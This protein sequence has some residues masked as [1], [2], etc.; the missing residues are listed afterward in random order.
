M[1]TLNWFDS[2]AAKPEGA[3][4]ITIGGDWAPI[5]TYEA[6]AR[7]RGAEIHGDL[8]PLLRESDF[9]LFN[10]E[11]V[12][13]DEGA[14]LSKPGP[15]L[16]AD[17]E[18]SISTLRGVPVQAVTLANNHAMDFGPASL[19]NTLKELDAAG[20]L[21]VGAGMA[22]PA[23]SA[24]LEVERD[25]VRFAVVNFGE[26]EA[27][28]SYG[29]RPGVNRYQPAVQAAQIR[30][31]KQRFPIVI[32][33]FHGGREHAVC[34]PPYVVEGMRALVDAGAD[35]VVAHHPHVPQGVEIYRGVPI[36]YST[37]N[38]VFRRGSGHYYLN[39]GYLA[40]LDLRD[41]RIVKVGLTPYRMAEAG[42]CRLQ[43][44][45]LAAFT[46]ELQ[47]LSGMLAHPDKVEA[48]WH[49][50][51]DELGENWVISTME[52]AVAVTKEDP[53]GGIVRWHHYFA[54]PAHQQMIETLFLR[55]RLG[56]VG[57]SPEW[58]REWV[59]RWKHRQID[60]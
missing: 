34:P 29:G 57:D 53:A 47:E 28:A 5:W 49:A 31:L 44:D 23:I 48:L 52:Q 1:N 19:E 30:E 14:P 60:A 40:H 9:N 27:C 55:H 17:A 8:L 36:A 4:R 3:F 20:I 41:G 50:F 43:G 13:G 38:F 16:K 24:P 15:C 6:V 32:A 22:E 58:A 59:R 42:V 45:E 10:L 46:A 11:A 51:G 25:G 21:H 37:G 26:G 18:L 12:L 2:E 7:E 39:T 35:A 54:M 56:T 33:V